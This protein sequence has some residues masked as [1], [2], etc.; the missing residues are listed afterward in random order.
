MTAKVASPAIACRG[1]GM[2]RS[3]KSQALTLHWGPIVLHSQSIAN[4]HKARAFCCLCLFS[5]GSWCYWIHWWFL[6]LCLFFFF[7]LFISFSVV[8]DFDWSLLSPLP[9]W[10]F[11]IT[12]RVVY[13][14]AM[15]LYLVYL[16]TQPSLKPPDGCKVS[17]LGLV[18]PYQSKK[19]Q[20]RTACPIIWDT[21][22][23]CL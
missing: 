7:Y 19:L 17:T 21:G 10:S 22:L 8:V 16:P 15:E 11:S 23:A 4:P 3:V 14:C 20:L 2:Q 12:Q 18:W 13:S 6:L 1:L 5:S 9:F